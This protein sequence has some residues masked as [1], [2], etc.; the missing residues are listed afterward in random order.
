[1]HGNKEIK[2]E[3][4]ITEI[5][6]IDKLLIIGPPG[7]GKTEVIRQKA[8]E[9]AETLGRI[10]VDLRSVDK[11]V[12]KD[13][14]REPSKYYLYLRI[15]AP[16]L[17][18]EDTSIPVRN[19]NYVEFTLPRL[20]YLFTL[21]NIAGTIFVD[22]LTNVVR[23]DQITLFFALLQEKEVGWAKL[24]DNV[25]IIAAAN[26]A[27]WSEVARVLPK[28]LRNRLIIIH[29]SPPTVNEWIEYM[30]R[31]YG[32]SWERLVAAFLKLYPEDFIKP[33]EEGD[34]FS[35]FPTPRSWSTL[36]LLL[37]RVKEGLK[38]AIIIGTVGK[39][40]GA[41]FITLMHEMS[42]MN[43]E[44]I[45]K[46]LREDPKVFDGL[47][48]SEKILIAH[49]LASHYREFVDI[50]EVL[51]DEWIVTIVMLIPMRERL[52]FLARAPNIAKKLSKKVA[53]LT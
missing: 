45:L 9:E 27:I 35:A 50:I 13:I 48:T 47:K 34:D 15:I 31:V 32:N 29:A 18:P 1:M 3:V 16:H 2:I 19:D 33:P 7:V 28:P 51:P 23:D 52:A 53:E 39:E 11:N 43:F 38:E 22:E 24:N 30:D 12:L 5:E 4:K 21:P 49:Y 26:D 10:F 6:L 41:K 42:K 37:R 20:L 17:L 46:R 36:A 40:A 44:D 8:Q 14:E 25:K